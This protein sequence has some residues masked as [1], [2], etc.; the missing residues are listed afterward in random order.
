MGD[1][2]RMYW[3]ETVSTRRMGKMNGGW[4]NHDYAPYP[5]SR[6]LTSLKSNA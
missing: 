1:A 6:T 4:K 2:P 3:G 5:N